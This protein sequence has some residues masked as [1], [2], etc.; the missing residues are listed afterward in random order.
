MAG[1]HLVL[2][3]RVIL[4]ICKEEGPPRAPF[5]VAPAAVWTWE[6]TNLSVV[7]VAC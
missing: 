4:G 7:S 3:D 5:T 6:R 2:L 1:D